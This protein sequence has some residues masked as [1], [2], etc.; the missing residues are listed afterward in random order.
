MTKESEAD[1]AAPSAWRSRAVAATVVAAGCLA[2]VTLGHIPLVRPAHAP[3]LAFD[4]PLPPGADIV[5][6]FDLQGDRRA[7][8][9]KSERQQPSDATTAIETAA[10]RAPRRTQLDPPLVSAYARAVDPAYPTGVVDPAAGLG[11]D[12]TG[13]REG[14]EAYRRGDLAKGDAAAASAKDPL[15][16][17]VLEWT[18]IRLKPVE[19]GYRRIARFMAAHPQWPGMDWLR[20]HAELALYAAHPPSR[21]VID[22][23]RADAPVT[24]SGRLALAAALL[25][26]GETASANDLAR[27]IWREDA[28]S[29]SQE[30]ALKKSFGAVLT[31]A[32]SARRASRLAY[33][34]KFS[35]A[36]RAASM[37]GPDIVALTQIR[38]AAERGVATDKTFADAPPA[39]KNDAGLAFARIKH[40]VRLKKYAEAGAAM[41]AAPRD[42]AAIIDGDA[43]WEERRSLAR[44]LLD[45]GDAGAAY[46]I[47]A[48]H[49]AEAN[50]K[51][52]EAEFMAG[53]IALRYLDKA[54][55]AAP[56][57]DKA[58]QI[59]RTPISRAR[60][61]YWRGRAAEAA[62]TETAKS[63]SIPFYETAAAESTAFY[64][65]LALLRLGRND[66]PI[67]LAP[68]PA[69][70]AARAESIRAIELL[71]AAGAKDV[72]V[73]LAY[74]A[75]KSIEAPEQMAALAS[76]V[77]KDRDAKVSLTLG[78]LA[79]QNGHPIDDV[80]FPTYGVPQFSPFV[81]SA[82]LPVVYSIAR[83]ESAFDPKAISHAGAMGLMQMIAS[84]ARS[85][86]RRVGVA[87]EAR[88]M[89]A[90]P[91]FNAQ[92]GAAHLGDLMKEQ[93]N[94]LILTFAA[95]NAG[96]R[97]VKEWIAAHGD[98]RDA[99]VDPID[100]IERI[101]IA[102]TRNYV[103]R[104]LENL[105]IYRARLGMS[106]KM[107]IDPLRK[108]ARM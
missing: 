31:A 66:T 84:T 48:G 24:P 35:A 86:A 4:I 37:A 57:F 90:D 5:L 32:D 59:A 22:F 16:T 52:I 80:A 3:K 20:K 8:L 10:P 29:M 51:Q 30:G 53:W 61:A 55:L 2:P 82:S 67:R 74:L 98:P 26:A 23:F 100:W 50:D 54:D 25:D 92:L 79:S 1:R 49:A 63:D 106:E 40:L 101:P 88:R 43:W 85:T 64:G 69:D 71:Y 76:A 73:P 13:L 36:L 38:A 15:V 103:Q 12:L 94:S 104:V 77:V 33:D 108:E 34:E 39:V 65:Q 70:G 47:C 44:K 91:V 95:Y 56:H 102:E 14:L 41:Q 83:Q 9:D 28:L 46:R 18:A 96:G 60:A 11:V 6:E 58:M 75:A 105:T 97:R 27:R 68:Q 87:F 72:A 19:I 17:T 93:R 107:A 81:N 62:P 42:P 78:K 89:T 21:N 7:E 99:S 45:A